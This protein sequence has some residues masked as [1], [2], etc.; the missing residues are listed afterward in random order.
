MIRSEK[1]NRQ[2]VEYPNLMEGPKSGIVILASGW[3]VNGTFIGMV[4][5]STK[6]EYPVGY[7]SEEWSRDFVPFA[8]SIMLEGNNGHR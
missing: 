4:V 3:K 1:T 7:Y 2:L 6:P 8:G 5:F